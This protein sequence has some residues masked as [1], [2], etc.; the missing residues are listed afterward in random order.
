MSNC[1]IAGI[2]A[3]YVGRY[4]DLGNIVTAFAVVQMLA[5]LYSLGEKQT[6]LEAV[7]Q[8]KILVVSLIAISGV[9]Y[10]TL[11]LLCYYAEIKAMSVSGFS[12]HLSSLSAWGAFGR[13][14]IV[15]LMTAFGLVVLRLDRP[16]GSSPPVK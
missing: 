15:L 8:R 13:L 2:G 16:L 11:V 9:V 3:A 6:I 14:L 4:W 1:E 7:R 10:S 12:S 5:F